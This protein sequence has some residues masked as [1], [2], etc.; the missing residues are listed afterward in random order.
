MKAKE[1]KKSMI[2]FMVKS[3]GKFQIAPQKNKKN[4]KRNV[5]QHADTFKP[6]YLKAIPVNAFPQNNA[7][8]RRQQKK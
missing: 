7:E 8:S 5:E 6:V 2:Q 3:L 1:R 4:P